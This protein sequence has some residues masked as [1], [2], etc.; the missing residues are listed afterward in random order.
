[1]GCK[2]S[3]GA[4]CCPLSSPLGWFDRRGCIL[5][6]GTGVTEVGFKGG[7]NFFS[8][9]ADTEFLRLQLLISKV[10]SS[11]DSCLGV[12]SHL[13]EFHAGDE[14]VVGADLECLF[15]SHQE[16]ELASLLVLEDLGLAQPSLLPLLGVVT[17]PEQLGSLLKDDLLSLLPS[18]H[19]HHLWQ[20]N[21]GGELHLWFIGLGFLSLTSL[22]SLGWSLGS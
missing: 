15:S 21:D 7:S 19:V 1:M 17:E 3:Q 20:G 13:V 10:L 9:E 4:S 6:L 2:L 12:G 14:L 16:A 8:F 22:C 11:P 18:D 5:G